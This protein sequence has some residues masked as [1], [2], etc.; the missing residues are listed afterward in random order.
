MSSDSDF[1]WNLF[2]ASSAVPQIHFLTRISLITVLFLPESETWRQAKWNR[3]RIISLSVFLGRRCDGLQGS[4]LF[5]FLPRF[6]LGCCFR[7]W[8]WLVKCC[9]EVTYFPTFFVVEFGEW[10][11]LVRPAW[12]EN[13]NRCFRCLFFFSLQ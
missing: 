6:C 10:G 8:K 9:H 4:F 5:G 12:Y 3:H 11:R 7:L 1:R 13:M 2:V